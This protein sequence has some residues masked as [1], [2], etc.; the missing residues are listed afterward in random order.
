[1]KG[2]LGRREESSITQGADVNVASGRRHDGACTG[3]PITATRRWRRA[4]QGA[5]KRQ[6][7]DA[8]RQLHAAALA[9]KAGSAP[10]VRA[11][12]KA[13]A[14]VKAVTTSGATPL[15]FAA[16]SGD[17]DAVGAMLDKGA[18]ANARETEWG[19]T[20]LIFAAEYDRPAAIKVLL[21]HGADPS[22]H[23]TVMNLTEETARE[24][25]ATR[26][27]NEVLISFEPKE[28]RDSINKAMAAAAAAAPP[29][30]S[31]GAG[32]ADSAVAVQQRGGRGGP[33]PEGTVHARAD[34]GRRSKPDA[35]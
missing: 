35:W 24:Q 13:G 28:R 22:I 25:A 3:P 27:R 5:R 20:P 14:D 26:K 23:T 2:D 18:N 32:P 30:D 9:G 31:S 15:H 7:D 16:Q 12:L 34:P 29:V 11:L 17:A 19:Q 1:M 10:V 8:H 33:Q 4:A 21:K 6:S